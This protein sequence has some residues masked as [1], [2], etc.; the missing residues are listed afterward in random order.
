[1]LRKNKEEEKE[2]AKEGEKVESL[3]DTTEE[4][5]EDEVQEEEEEE[6]EEEPV[7]LEP[8]KSKRVASRKEKGNAVMVYPKNPKEKIVVEKSNFPLLVNVPRKKWNY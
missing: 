5:T 2:Q 6:V 4:N 8:R 3:P 7:A 1:M